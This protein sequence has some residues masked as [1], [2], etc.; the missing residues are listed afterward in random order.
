M[1]QELCPLDVRFFNYP[2]IEPLDFTLMKNYYTN[3]AS[4]KKTELWK[5]DIYLIFLK[6]QLNIINNWLNL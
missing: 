6:Y 2:D 1:N 3:K 5:L 4:I